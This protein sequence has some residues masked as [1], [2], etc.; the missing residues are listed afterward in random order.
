M[1]R[2]LRIREGLR[3]L[4]FYS[5]SGIIIYL[6]CFLV[7]YGITVQ[8]CGYL[9]SCFLGIV[10]LIFL[11]LFSSE[12]TIIN[13][14]HIIHKKSLGLNKQQF[15]FPEIKLIEVE[16][17][18]IRSSTYK[19]MI[20]IHG[21]KNASFGMIGIENVKLFL[22]KVKSLYPN[23]IRVDVEVISELENN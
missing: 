18:L 5:S 3:V 6:I 14:S 12:T 21:K 16:K 10:S 22:E 2:E 17:S 4:L 15:S 9:V 1:N 20:R 8:K 11:T 7:V 23:I 19:Y 13:E